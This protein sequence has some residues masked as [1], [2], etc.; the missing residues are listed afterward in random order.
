MVLEVYNRLFECIQT[1]DYEMS[2]WD[3]ERIRSMQ[4]AGYSFKLDGR[5]I[6]IGKFIEDKI[7]CESQPNS[8]SLDSL[9]VAELKQIAK[10][11]MDKF[12]EENPDMMQKAVDGIYKAVIDQ[13][14]SSKTPQDP[15]L[16]TMIEC[17]ETGKLYDKQAHAAR[18]L[19][20]DPSYVSDS[21][22]TGKKHKG[23]SF[24]KVL[25]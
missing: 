17:I 19:G 4:Q 22:K 20:I 24:R 13:T 1:A 5:W 15:N 25:V 11:A 12:V 3:N 23:Y 8:K 6:A 7:N 14:E 10:D 18:D 16:K 21:I 2:S 9:T